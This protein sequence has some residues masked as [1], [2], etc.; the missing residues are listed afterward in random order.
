MGT[1]VINLI[2]GIALGLAVLALLGVVLMTFCDKYK[3]RYLMYFSCVFLFFF[4]VLGF[5]IAIIFSILVPVM[6]FMCEWLDVTVSSTG[7]DTNVQ[8]FISDATIRGYIT[9]C[10][11]GGSGD[12]LGA[13]GGA[14]IATTINGLRDSVQDTNTFNTTS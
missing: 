6:Y 1:L 12:L 9:P 13:V 2:Y 11:S 5:L 4:G 8:K 7:F 3:C 10:L 14:T